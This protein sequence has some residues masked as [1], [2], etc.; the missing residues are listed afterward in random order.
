[1]DLFIIEGEVGGGFI[2]WMRY[3]MFFYYVMILCMIVGFGNVL[4]NIDGERIFFICCMLMGG[5]CYCLFF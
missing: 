5:K 3:F 2:F 4:V 1:M